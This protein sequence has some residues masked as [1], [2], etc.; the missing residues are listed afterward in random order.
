MISSKRPKSPSLKKIRSSSSS[1]LKKDKSSSKIIRNGFRS[2]PKSKRSHKKLMIR[3]TPTEKV[4]NPSDSI[5]RSHNLMS[6]NKKL[7]GKF[8][9]LPKIKT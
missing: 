4:R 1:S 3:K 8:L 2:Y 7:P 5:K 9:F 6:Q